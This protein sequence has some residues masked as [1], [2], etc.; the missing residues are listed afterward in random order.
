MGFME[1]NPE[2]LIEYTD[3]SRRADSPK[4]II[5]NV[6]PNSLV[7]STKTVKAGRLIEEVNGRQI[8]D[9]S[10]LCSALSPAGGSQFWTMK[11][12]K[13]L[14]VLNASAVRESMEAEKHG[15]SACAALI[16]D[17][18]RTVPAPAD[19]TANSGELG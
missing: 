13:G 14:T 10:S 2:E 19:I 18:S 3:S 17:M 15:G 9:L 11:T 16:R 6:V 12:A 7:G 1:D 4:M 8:T 5:T